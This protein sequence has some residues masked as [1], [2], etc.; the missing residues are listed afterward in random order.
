MQQPLITMRN[1]VRDGKTG[2]RDA[3]LT[4]S[5]KICIRKYACLVTTLTDTQLLVCSLHKC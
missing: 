5:N 3:I 1:G 4:G 2:V